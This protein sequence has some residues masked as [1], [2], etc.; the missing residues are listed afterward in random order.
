MRGKNKNESTIADIL[1]EVIG[2][3]KLQEGINQ[4][5]VRNLWHEV[6]GNG[7]SAYTRQV[8]LK[9]GTLY[10]DL[11]SSVLREE[12]YYGKQK[13]MTILNEALGRQVIQ[14]IVLR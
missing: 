1:K 12:L 13:I 6:L 11:T 2:N 5:E 9:G 4:V 8:A 14:E 3:G 10:V 7:V